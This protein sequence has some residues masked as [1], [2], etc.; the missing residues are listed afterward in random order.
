MP[1][2]RVAHL[3]RPTGHRRR[4]SSV[5][6]RCVA[7][8]AIVFIGSL[9]DRR[10]ADADSGASTV[11][12]SGIEAAVPGWHLHSGGHHGVAAC[13]WIDVIG[14]DNLINDEMMAKIDADHLN[15]LGAFEGFGGSGD[16]FAQAAWIKSH[17]LVENLKIYQRICGGATTWIVVP[18]VNNTPGVAQVVLP[19]L[20]SKYT[21]AP[22][23]VY[24]PLDAEFRWAYVQIPLAV[25]TTPAQWKSYSVT[26]ENENVPPALKRWV[27][28]TATPSQFRFAPGD[29]SP[30]MTCNGDAPIAA[31]D[32]AAPGPCAVTFKH[33]SSTAA[34]GRS[35]AVHGEITWTV[36]Y[37]SSTGAGVLNDIVL[38]TDGN[39]E[40]AAIKA[41]VGCTGGRVGQGG[42]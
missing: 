32:P 18:V 8:V 34:N 25:R 28:V 12:G 21:K 42:C 1:S 2:P 36:A 17:P 30:D 31:Y 27:T 33:E 7:L 29:G 23:L 16:S 13:D 3:S 5:V 14:P 37:T 40:V 24:K 11:G 20:K 39:I 19:D 26:A 10:V 22:E 4:W 35:F 15:Y 41:L 9:V 6:R 38:G